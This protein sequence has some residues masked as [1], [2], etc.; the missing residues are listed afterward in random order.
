[1]TGGIAAVPLL[2]LLWL[3][4]RL[5]DQDRLLE[6]QRIQDRLERAADLAAASRQRAIAATGQ[7]LADGNL[8]WP[9]GSATIVIQGGRVEA[10]PAS[11]V[12]FVP[13]VH[14]LMEAAP[15]AFARGEEFEFRLH[16]RGAAK[17]VVQLEPI[18]LRLIAYGAGYLA[19]ATPI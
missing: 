18:R 13:V 1:M 4:W 16:D 5:L 7:R 10:H 6:G 17:V 12:A 2:T 14:P 8:D 9:D 11:R 3:G 19:I 15:S